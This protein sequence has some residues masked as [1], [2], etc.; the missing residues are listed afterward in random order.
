[1]L[2]EGQKILSS[3]KVN[4]DLLKD[5]IRIFL[6]ENIDKVNDSTDKLAMTCLIDDFD[7]LMKEEE[8]QN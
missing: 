6:K 8:M 1:M 7:K 5:H 4:T 3:Y 2:E